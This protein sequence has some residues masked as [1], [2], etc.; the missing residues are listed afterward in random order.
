MLVG[1]CFD[2]SR[3]TLQIKMLQHIV[4]KGRMKKVQS[5]YLFRSPSFNPLCFQDC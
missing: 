3:V 5:Q 2:I 4:N 1:K